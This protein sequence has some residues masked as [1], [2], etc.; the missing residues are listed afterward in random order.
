MR[1]RVLGASL[2][3][4]AVSAACFHTFTRVEVEPIRA[5]AGVVQVRS[6]VKAHMT[7]GSVVVFRD[8]VEVSGDTVRGAG[9]RYGVGLNEE[10]EVRQITL[11]QL[12]GIESY[13][14]EIDAGKSAAV[15]LLATIGIP[16]LIVGGIVVSFGSCPTIYTKTPEGFVLEAEAFSYSIAPLLESRDVDLLGTRADASGRVNLEVRNEALETHYINHFELLEVAHARG[17]R[18]LPDFEGQPI[19]VGALTGASRMTD[20]AGRDVSSMLG[21]ADGLA[22]ATAPSRL[23]AVSE[24]DFNDHIELSFPLGPARDSAALVLRG[25]NSLLNTVLFYDFML[26]RSGARSLDWLGTDLQRIGPAVELGSWFYSRMGMRVS[27]RHADGWREVARVSDAGPLAWKDL[28]VMLPVP[29]DVDSLDVRLSFVADG[30]RIDAAALDLRPRRAGARALPLREVLVDGE[31]SDDALLRMAN[32][33]ES[34]L[35]VTPA[36][37]LDLSFYAGPSSTEQDRTF[38]LSSQ[39]YYTEWIRPQW[40]R[41]ASSATP[42]EASD[43][44]LVETLRVWTNVKAEMERRFFETRIPVR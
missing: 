31:R 7:D 39:G 1:A 15:S 24:E 40:I 36:H 20:A 28:A 6:P 4:A 25:R 35:V 9:V 5:S 30:W 19:V 22:Y 34:Y 21:Q 32:P 18:A 41:E 23:A 3:L 37:R 33:D 8:G 2:A 17:E 43:R 11:D 27:V 42:F 13:R 29:E 38:L 10:G 16:A 44:T 26:G 14:Q 12:V